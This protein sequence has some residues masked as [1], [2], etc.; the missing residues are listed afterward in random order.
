[1]QLPSPELEC[2]RPQP[3]QSPPGGCSGPRPARSTT[4]PAGPES[5]R[6][7]CAQQS[8]TSLSPGPRPAQAP[9]TARQSAPGSDPDPGPRLRHWPTSQYPM[10]VTARRLDPRH[11]SLYPAPSESV[12]LQLCCNST[13]RF[14]RRCNSTFRFHRPRRIRQHP[15]RLRLA[16]VPASR[17]NRSSTRLLQDRPDRTTTFATTSTSAARLSPEPLLHWTRR[18]PAAQRV[19]L[20]RH[21]PCLEPLAYRCSGGSPCLPRARRQPSFLRR[22]RSLVRRS[23]RPLGRLRLPPRRATRALG[24]AR[25]QAAPDPQI[26]PA[27]L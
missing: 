11:P 9:S 24:P 17:R 21:R 7:R 13:F 25:A 3:R 22:P 10:A 27:T 2:Q 1:M 5:E 15:P 12:E 18:R 14:L 4:R 20:L 16:P 19:L 26:R 8:V 6:I 23:L